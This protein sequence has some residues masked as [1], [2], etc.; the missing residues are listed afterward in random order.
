M[1]MKQE[2]VVLT[3]QCDTSEWKIVEQVLIVYKY[4]HFDVKENRSSTTRWSRP[5]TL[6]LLLRISFQAIL[7]V[8]NF[9]RVH[10]I[11]LWSVFFGTFI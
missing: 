7:L 3:V 4:I 1:N 2:L 6:Q 11:F 10:S 5:T 8:R 9:L